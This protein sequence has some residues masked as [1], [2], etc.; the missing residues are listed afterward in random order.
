VHERPAHAHN[1]HMMTVFHVQSG[2]TSWCEWPSLFLYLLA[3][4]AQGISVSSL[5]GR[6]QRTSSSSSPK[7]NNTKIL[8]LRCLRWPRFSIFFFV[9]LFL[10][11]PSI[12]RLHLVPLYLSG[13]LHVFLC[14]LAYGLSV[15]FSFSLPHSFL[16]PFL[17]AVRSIR[18]PCCCPQV[19]VP[20]SPR[21]PSGVHQRC[22]P[23]RPITKKRNQ[24]R[25]KATRGKIVFLHF[26]HLPALL[27]VRPTWTIKF[28][29]HEKM[30]KLPTDL[31]IGPKHLS[32]DECNTTKKM[33]NGPAD[34][35]KKMLPISSQRWST[36]KNTRC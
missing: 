4:I 13:H 18:L 8:H 22:S 2:K 10:L 24:R 23:N 11:A 12:T 25:R 35:H 14:L 36:N 28:F 7:G 30:T 34:F 33:A 27:P 1:I 29:G 15:F 26:L 21:D 16:L 3:C 31:A 19:C 20:V 32:Q 6:N 17:A 9:S 5:T